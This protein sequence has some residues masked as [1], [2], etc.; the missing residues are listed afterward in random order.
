M[1]LTSSC[2]ELWQWLS[3]LQLL[4]FAYFVYFCLKKISSIILLLTP[5]QQKYW[6]PTFKVSLSTP[7]Y[8]SLKM[9]SVTSAG[10]VFSSG[11]SHTCT[12]VT[13]VLL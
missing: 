13:V 10:C 11:K 9:A 3:F 4:S 12:I 8:I 7:L 5:T 1:Y 2:I 6:N